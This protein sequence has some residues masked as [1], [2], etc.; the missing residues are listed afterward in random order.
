MICETCGGNVTWRGLITNLT[1]TE[2]ESCG[3]INN[4]IVD[5]PDDEEEETEGETP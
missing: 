5:Q 4:Q 3:R 1:H 2:C